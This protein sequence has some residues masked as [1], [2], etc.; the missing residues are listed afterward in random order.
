MTK[1]YV[2]TV[3]RVSFHT[4]YYSAENHKAVVYVER[5]Q[6]PL[7]ELQD[8]KTEHIV[9]ETIHPATN[10]EQVLIENHP[11]AKIHWKFEREKLPQ[12]IEA[13]T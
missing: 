7:L 10:A 12:A 6:E 5:D 3:K 13:A 9:T 8:G 2:R 11:M 4:Q 1:L